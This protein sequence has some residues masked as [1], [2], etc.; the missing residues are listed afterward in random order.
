MEQEKHSLRWFD[1]HCHFCDIIDFDGADI[2]EEVNAAEKVGVRKF[3]SCAYKKKHFDWHL[4]YPHSNM[5]WYAGIH[6]MFA[7]ETKKEVNL[8]SELAHQKRIVAIGEIGL[9]SRYNDQELQEKLLLMQLEIAR[10]YDLPVVFHSVGRYYDLYKIIKKNFPKTRGVLHSFASSEE[11]FQI[12]KSLGFGF[13]LG[14][15]ILLSRNHEKVLRNILDWSLYMIETDA[16]AQKPYFA[17]T[18]FSKLRYLPQI[19]GKLAEIGEID[20]HTLQA[21]SWKSLYEIGFPP[22]K[23]D[24]QV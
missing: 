17:E 1:F 10:M 20:L 14:A 22:E 11:V 18:E 9:D 13:S 5:E 12:F 24:A 23:K 16:P 4:A 21:K 3:Y 2:A 8:V 7:R 6:P 15:S 19:A